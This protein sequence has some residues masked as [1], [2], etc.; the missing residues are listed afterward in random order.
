MFYLDKKQIRSWLQKHNVENAV[1]ELNDDNEFVV[2]VY[3]DVNLG[4]Q[5]LTSIPVKFGV[6]DGNFIAVNNKL[7][8]LYGCPSI[9]KK[10]F[11]VSMNHLTTLEGGPS[12]VEE[13][14]CC[15]HNNLS[16]LNG[17][18]KKI[19]G[20]LLASDNHI[21]TIEYL[22]LSCFD[23]NMDRNPGLLEFENIRDLKTLK[24]HQIIL[25][26]RR[27]LDKALPLTS[28]PTSSSHVIKL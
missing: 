2:N 23:I 10:R 25:I 24:K 16:S 11:S 8:S 15:T 13:N 3:G 22:P 14:Y 6:V 19:K 12:V 26:E 4:N 1:I 28:N 9:V 5:N 27:D 21:T 7:T 17:V 20:T 18:A